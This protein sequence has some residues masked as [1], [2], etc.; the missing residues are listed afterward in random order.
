MPKAIVIL[1]SEGRVSAGESAPANEGCRRIADSFA[2]L[3]LLGDSVLN[4]VLGRLS[5]EGI[6]PILVTANDTGPDLDADSD[7]A[8]DIGDAENVWARS[9]GQI[10]KLG[11]R[12]E[13]AA[14][15]MRLGRYTEL[16]PAEL[17]QFRSESGESVVRAFK[18]QSALEVWA[19]DPARV[20]EV[21]QATSSSLQSVLFKSTARYALDGYVNQLSSPRD[22]RTLVGDALNGRCGLRPLGFEVRPG[23]WM[24]EGAQIE[25]EA[26][27]VAPAFIGENVTVSRQ[28]LI[29][30]GSNIERDSLVDYGT[31]IEDTSVLPNT[32]VGIGLD[33]SHSIVDGDTLLNLQHGVMVKV[34]DT[35]VMR[36]NKELGGSEKSGW[37]TSF[38]TRDR[39][40]ASVDEDA[41]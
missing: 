28:C 34:E 6:E 3:E 12:G 29:T 38:K 22:V 41:A 11:A 27:I 20:A 15:V 33:V 35:M 37:W 25:S 4:R 30:R 21:L 17:L 24:A 23:V 19:V 16:N 18:D 40:E 9:E 7:S 1:E 8:L 31:V 32:Y 5:A 26:R 2:A 39:V 10:T 36:R 14:L 13:D